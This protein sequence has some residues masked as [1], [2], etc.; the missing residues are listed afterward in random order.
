MDGRDQRLRLASDQVENTY[1]RGRVGGPHR[2]HARF[3]KSEG[4][5]SEVSEIV[6][7]YVRNLR[8]QHVFLPDQFR[9]PLV[10]EARGRAI[11]QPRRHESLY[12]LSRYPQHLSFESPRPPRHGVGKQLLVFLDALNPGP[13]QRY[14]LGRS[15]CAA[16]AV[17]VH[18]PVGRKA[19]LSRAFLDLHV[20]AQVLVVLDRNRRLVLAGTHDSLEIVAGPV[21]RAGVGHQDSAQQGLLRRARI[22]GGTQQRLVAAVALER[23]GG[24]QCCVP[25]RQTAFGHGSPVPL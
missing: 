17:V 23:K 9:H 4:R 21:V 24:A 12:R 25:K 11:E 2:G 20:L 5:D 16:G 13:R 8:R 22:P 3:R 10:Q 18:R 6:I 1:K 14:V 19:G 7:G 15:C